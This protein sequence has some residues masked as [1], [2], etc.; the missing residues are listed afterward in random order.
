MT[1]LN[2]DSEIDSAHP[3]L[4]IPM[5][6]RKPKGEAQYLKKD[7]RTTACPEQRERVV[8]LISF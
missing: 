1:L 7:Y 5:E 8:S 3:H 4:S 6:G 2:H